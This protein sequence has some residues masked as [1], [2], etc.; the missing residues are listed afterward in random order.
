[1][2]QKI[3]IKYHTLQ[4]LRIWML[5]SATLTFNR[6]MVVLLSLSRVYII[7]RA[8]IG[9]RHDDTRSKLTK[10]GSNISELLHMYDITVYMEKRTQNNCHFF[11][12]F[13]SLCQFQG[14][15]ILIERAL[16]YNKQKTVN[17]GGLYFPKQ[18]CVQIILHL[19]WKK[20]LLVLIGQRE[21]VWLC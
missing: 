14:Q 11:V 6:W 10:V 19:A 15:A 16:K 5:T 1:M 9:L 21:I 18:P 4:C 17:F 12:L 7:K 8:M 13:V 3:V 20:L 2:Y